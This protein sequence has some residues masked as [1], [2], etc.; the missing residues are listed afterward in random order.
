MSTLLIT[1]LGT[2]GYSTVDYSFRGETFH[3]SMVSAA[4]ADALKPD[5]VLVLCTDDAW[6]VNGHRVASEIGP[7]VAGR[8]E[9]KRLDDGDSAD[10]QN[11]LFGAYLEA[12]GD[13]SETEVLLDITLGFRAQ[14]FLASTAVA[15]ALFAES[16]KLA[17]EIFYGGALP[18]VSAGQTALVPVWELTSGVLD[19]LRWA[20]GLDHLLHTGIVPRHLLDSLT[21]QGRRHRDSERAAAEPLDAFAKSVT[22]YANDLACVNAPD[23]LGPNGSAGAVLSRIAQLDQSLVLVP[24]MK[25]VLTRL[26]AQLAPLCTATLAE[27]PG[28]DRVMAALAR[29]Y[30]NLGRYAE[31]ATIVR[32][33][34]VSLAGTHGALGR[35][36]TGK[37]VGAEGNIARKELERLAFELNPNRFRNTVN[38]RNALDH[39]G[40]QFGDGRTPSATLIAAVSHQVSLLEAEVSGSGK[41]D[42]SLRE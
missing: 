19:A 17:L 3:R 11:Q 38:V 1:S 16:G 20:R 40:F 35:D 26:Q 8:V 33:T 29:H 31:A 22:L 37:A 25:S 6:S 2:L 12:I 23:L 21:Q 39:A 13:S 9:R 7:L 14:P 10:G 5:R 15:M 34:W 36:P 27:K 24:A 18:K 41:N 42:P 28:G 4:L 32:E 30:L